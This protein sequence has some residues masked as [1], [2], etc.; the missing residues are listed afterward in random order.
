[1]ISLSAITLVRKSSI[2]K[3]VFF[4]DPEYQPTKSASV[5]EFE[6]GLIEQ[7]CLKFSDYYLCQTKES[8]INWARNKKLKCLIF[9]FET[10]GNKYFMKR[11]V[12]NELRSHNIEPVFHMRDWD[13]Y[14]FHLL[15]KG[16]FLF[17]KNI[18][19]LLLRNKVI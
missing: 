4:Y 15:A 3:G 13:K 11:E 12:I 5:R 19:A 18:S 9:P 6:T 10:T 16:F 14:F 2:S 1:M 8:L 17:K 7:L